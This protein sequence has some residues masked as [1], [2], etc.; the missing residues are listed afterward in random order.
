MSGCFGLGT[1]LSII[2]LTPS[3]YGVGIWRDGGMRIS[4]G[5][6]RGW[7]WCETLGVWLGVEEGTVQRETAPWLRFFRPDGS[8]ILLPEEEV[9]QERQR[10]EVE[11]QRAEVE[12]QRAEAERQRAE[13]ALA[14]LERLKA[15]LGEER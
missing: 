1:I 3:R 15:Q 9:Q 11:R 13:A 4:P 14:E 6:I 8:L 2:P 5:A 10:A 12:R 7:L